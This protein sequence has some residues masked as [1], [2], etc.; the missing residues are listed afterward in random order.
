MKRYIVC[1]KRKDETRWSV[2]TDTNDVNQITK[3]VNRI[4]EI[5]Y[6]AKVVDA[7]IESFEKKLARGYL[8]ETPVYI[9]QTVYAINDDLAIETWEVKALHYDGKTWFA[10]DDTGL[11]YDVGS[12]WCLGTHSKANRVLKELKG[13]TENDEG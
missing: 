3:H 5:G 7:K 13:E 2:W 1:A 4:R 12:R 9:G 6:D 11:F 10:I 8:L